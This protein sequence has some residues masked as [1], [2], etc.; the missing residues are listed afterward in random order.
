MGVAFLAEVCQPRSFVAGGKA[1]YGK[2]GNP[3]QRC[4]RRRFADLGNSLGL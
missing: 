1:F 4:Q 3:V 2:Q